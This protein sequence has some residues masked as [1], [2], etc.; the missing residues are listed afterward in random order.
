MVVGRMTQCSK[1]DR[2]VDSASFQGKPW[3]LIT[4]VLPD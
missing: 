1:K 3:P 4:V 2:S